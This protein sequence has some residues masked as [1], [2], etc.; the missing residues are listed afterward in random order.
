[1]SAVRSDRRKGAGPYLVADSV[2]KLGPET[3][4]AVVL[5]ASHGGSYPAHLVAAAGL[6]AVVLN[7]AGFGRERAGVAGLLDLEEIGLPAAA[8][9]HRSARIG[10]GADGERRG[11][12]S[13]VNAPARALGLVVGMSAREGAALLAERAPDWR[14]RSP[15]AAEHRIAAPLSGDGP[16]AWLLDSVSQVEPS[17]A[18]DIVVTGSH[19]GLLGQNPASAIKADVFAALFN[20]ADVGIDGAGITRLPA[21]D[22]R[23]IAAATVSAWSARIGDGRSTFEDGFI[24]HLNETALRFGASVG[25]SARAFVEAMRDAWR[26]AAP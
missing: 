10:D 15:E 25:T 12:L 17:D 24:T 1:M 2:T 4:N 8:I 22:A 26:R 5:A 7:D 19:G 14:G 20:D 6:R 9:S 23:G 13:C 18:G 11:L 21:L 16:P 3:R